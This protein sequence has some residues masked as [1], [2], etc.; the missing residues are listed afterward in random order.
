LESEGEFG[1]NNVEGRDEGGLTTALGGIGG[2]A[3]NDCV[4]GEITGGEMF[5][6]L[7]WSPLATRRCVGRS[8]SSYDK[9]LK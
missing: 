7:A 8:K 9:L 2:G 6:M 4:R 1:S 3:G 5:M